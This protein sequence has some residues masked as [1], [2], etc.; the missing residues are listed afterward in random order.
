MSAITT[1]ADFH[2]PS[3][4]VE[5]GLATADLL[6][7]TGGASASDVYAVGRMGT[8]LHRGST[9]HWDAQES[10]TAYTLSS[11]W[12]SPRGFVYA[13]GIDPANASGAGS[14]FFSNGFG[15]WQA[16][17]AVD[18]TGSPL[19]IGF[20]SVSGGASDGDIWAVAGAGI[21]AHPSTDADYATWQLSHAPNGATKAFYSVS[22]TRSGL[23]YACGE[24]G[25]CAYTRGIAEWNSVDNTKTGTDLNILAVA[26]APK[27]DVYLATSSA[28][29]MHYTAGGSFHPE[30]SHLLVG[31]NGIF[32]TDSDVFAVGNNGAI[33]HSSG[34]GIWAQEDWNSGGDGG[35]L[36]QLNGVW[37]AASGDVFVVGESGT[38][39]HKY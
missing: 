30:D 3:W 39:L 1:P 19:N 16:Q 12:E 32:A 27:G 34:N 21:I 5:S 31:L 25:Y 35:A 15:F 29:I 20:R 6:S 8:I 2:T 4:H 37:Q 18:S 36:P 24:G 23:A 17:Y 22:V 28:Q 14:V 10:Y 13:T 33:V 38:I 26:V 9:Q 11:V 7:V